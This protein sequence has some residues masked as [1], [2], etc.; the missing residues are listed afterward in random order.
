[1]GLDLTS[2]RS[3]SKYQLQIRETV[4]IASRKVFSEVGRSVPFITLNEPIFWE[5]F[6]NGYPKQNHGDLEE[7]VC[8]IFQRTASVGVSIFQGF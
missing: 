1:M 8:V 3:Y 6:A 4:S 5:I 2:R 7:C